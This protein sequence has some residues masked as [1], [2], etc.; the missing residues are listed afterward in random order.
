[1]TEFAT[2][3]AAHPYYWLFAMPAGVAIL[4][5]LAWRSLAGLQPG[6]RRTALYGGFALA[7]SALF[8]VLAAAVAQ[9]GGMVAFDTA[10]AEALG[11]QMPGGLLAGLSWF[12]FLGDRYFLLLL[13][14]LMLALL[15]W[16]RRWWLCGTA[17]LATAGGGALNWVLKHL[18]QRVRP[19]H[20][21]GYIEATG[22]SF[23][24]GH[25]SAS[26]IIYG[27]GC[28][29]LL[30][31][32]PERW[33]MACIA[34]AAGLVAAI[35]ASRILLHVHFFSDVVAGFAV[36]ALWLA[37][38]VFLAERCLARQTGR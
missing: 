37:L 17:V 10:L 22:F 13:S 3:A 36:S 35:G 5:A 4:A 20:T 15:A 11:E 31:L 26:L 27:F 19:E 21:H 6:W 12:T 34:V 7:M 25:A 32:L 28:Y 16:R 23:P 24:S 33:H 29:L 14:V 30:R 8:L 2:W 1:M 38:C 9:P 18:F